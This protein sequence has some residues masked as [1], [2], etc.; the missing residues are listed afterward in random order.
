MLRFLFMFAAEAGG[1]MLNKMIIYFV[2]RINAAS[3]VRQVALVPDALFVGFTSSPRVVF[4]HHQGRNLTILNY[5]TRFLFG[6]FTVW[7]VA[8]TY[9]SMVRLDKIID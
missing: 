8:S 5:R 9:Y 4:L 6:I 3:T 7:L 1:D 2:Y